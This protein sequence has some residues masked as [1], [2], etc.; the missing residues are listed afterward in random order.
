MDREERLELAALVGK[1]LLTRGRVQAQS[2]LLADRDGLDVTAVA[3]IMAQEVREAPKSAADMSFRNMPG[4]KRVQNVR[5]DL[6]I[7]NRFDTHYPLPDAIL[8]L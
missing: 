2:L 6:G 8:I 1:N 4:V 5:K 3:E 7:C